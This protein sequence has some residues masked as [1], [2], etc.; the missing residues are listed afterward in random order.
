VISRYALRDGKNK[1]Q[2]YFN[3]LLFQCLASGVFLMW[4]EI[5]DTAL[6]LVYGGQCLVFYIGYKTKGF[7]YNAPQ[8]NEHE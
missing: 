8:H 5:E 2:R 6:K 1:F 7:K 3:Y 4:L